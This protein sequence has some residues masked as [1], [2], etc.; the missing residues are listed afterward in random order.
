MDGPRCVRV[1]QLLGTLERKMRLVAKFRAVLWLV[2]CFSRCERNADV[3]RVQI[4]RE[5]LM[6]PTDVGRPDRRRR[7]RAGARGVRIHGLIETGN[8]GAIHFSFNA[9]VA[10][11]ETSSCCTGTRVWTRKSDKFLLT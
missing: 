7:A 8:C 10:S 2:S 3:D 9:R 4:H 6:R 5:L 11:M 1:C